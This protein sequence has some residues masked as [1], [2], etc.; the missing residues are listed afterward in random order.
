MRL[1]NTQ[2]MRLLIFLN[3]DA[4]LCTLRKGK[5]FPLDHAVVIL[6][7]GIAGGCS[8]HEGSSR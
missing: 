6:Q 3:T 8:N 1:A 5:K 2:H 4:K 7:S